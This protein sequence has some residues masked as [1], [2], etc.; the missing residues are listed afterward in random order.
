MAR[1]NADPL[2]HEIHEALYQVRFNIWALENGVDNEPPRSDLARRIL[3][4]IQ[5]FIEEE[6]NDLYRAL[7][8][9]LRARNEN[10]CNSGITNNESQV[11]RDT[12]R[13]LGVYLSPN[14][15]RESD[16][17]GESDCSVP[18]LEE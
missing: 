5:V 7:G 2:W 14:I 16:S 15:D 3:G 13:N 17:E 1:T 10:A 9:H 4:E 18:D 8:C 6:N 12:I 11:E